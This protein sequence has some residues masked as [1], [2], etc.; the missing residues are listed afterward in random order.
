MRSY[1]KFL[2][3]FFSISFFSG[4]EKEH[5]LNLHL[6]DSVRKICSGKGSFE[7]NLSDKEV[8]LLQTWIDDNKLGWKRSPASYVGYISFKDKEFSITLVE[9]FVVINEKQNQWVKGGVDLTLL[10]GVCVD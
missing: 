1:V 7:R 9:D 5:A 2:I 10:K 6:S 8:A 4:C 3:L